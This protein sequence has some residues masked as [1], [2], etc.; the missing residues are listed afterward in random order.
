MISQTIRTLQSNKQI[1]FLISSSNHCHVDHSLNE[2]VD[3]R[4]RRIGKKSVSKKVRGPQDRIKGGP[5]R[6]FPPRFTG[7][8]PFFVLYLTRR[9]SQ[10]TSGI[11]GCARFTQ[12]GPRNYS[13]RIHSLSRMNLGGKGAG[14][15]EFARK[16]ISSLLVNLDSW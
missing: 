4:G 5:R 2:Q 9:T 14:I 1:H 11:R 13:E 10:N 12:P 8:P 7:G 16:E 6:V 3:H 15:G